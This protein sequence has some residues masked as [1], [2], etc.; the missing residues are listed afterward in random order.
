MF[1]STYFIAITLPF[2]SIRLVSSPCPALQATLPCPYSLYVC[3]TTLSLFTVCMI[4]LPQ[5]SINVCNVCNPSICH[6]IETTFETLIGAQN[7]SI[8]TP[9]HKSIHL[10]CEREA[11][12]AYL[13]LRHT[14]MQINGFQYIYEVY[15]TTEQ[16]RDPHSHTL[17]S[18]Q[19]QIHSNP[20][21]ILNLK[22]LFWELFCVSLELNIRTK[23]E[24]LRKF[25]A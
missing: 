4:W 22:V 21:L 7:H 13:I 17:N 8:H 1:G 24:F 25:W 18:P 19:F 12:K 2:N 15:S 9:K 10:L 11:R 5:T 16:H 20:Y 23:Y 6:K 14:F 3:Y